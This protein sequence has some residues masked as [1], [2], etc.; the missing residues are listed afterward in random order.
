MSRILRRPMFRGGRVDSRGTG[1]TSGLSYAKGGSVNIP[2]R[3]L[4]D[5]PGGYAGEI[6]SLE[7]YSGP[8]RIPQSMIGNLPSWFDINKYP[9]I[10]KNY[11]DMGKYYI[12]RGGFGEKGTGAPMREVDAKQYP[13]FKFNNN[14]FSS[15]YGQP[16]EVGQDIRNY[17]RTKDMIDKQM[18]FS[19]ESSRPFNEP[20]LP[21][22]KT[23]EKSL[24]EIMKEMMGTKKS[25][26]EKVKEYREMFKDA[27]GSGV[28]DDASAMALS[29]AKNALAPDAT[30]KSAFAGFFDD[31]YKRPSQRKKYDDA[32][33]TA[34]I[35][36]YLTGEKDYDSL[37]KQMK[38]IDY[39]ID[40]K[41]EAAKANETLD[42]LLETYA[43]NS[44]DR[45]DAGVMQAAFNRLYKDKEGYAGFIGPL[46]E[47]K[48][49]LIVGGIYYAD[50]PNDTRT[51]IIYEIDAS[52]TPQ[53]I[54]SIMK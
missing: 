25:P 22:E 45:T 19:G 12:Q 16:N 32:A 11:D 29:F 21:K 18:A 33:T 53:K 41:A 2:K 37:M 51:K 52:G 13:M 42:V 5:G 43:G 17:S 34:A 36:A 49:D 4:V 27:Y 48:E 44:G 28:A 38:I 9:V 24:E 47:N 8:V 23:E 26:K 39:Q 54:R 50:D 1:I 14:P 35:Q 3:G 31:E 46:P 20:E 40:K 6:G 7:G 15:E 30:V 10:Y